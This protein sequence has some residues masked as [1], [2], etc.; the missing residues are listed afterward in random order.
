[1]IYY[2]YI[3]IIIGLVDVK[4]LKIPTRVVIII[5]IIIKGGRLTT[6][7]ADNT[8]YTFVYQRLDVGIWSG[9]YNRTL[10]PVL[11]SVF[12]IIKKKKRNYN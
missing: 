2:T 6:Y 7:A 8:Q 12:V 9:S 3:Y 1:M 4:Q 5:I 11:F 10:L